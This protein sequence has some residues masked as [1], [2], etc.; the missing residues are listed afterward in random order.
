MFRAIQVRST[1]SEKINK[2]KEY[3]TIRKIRY[4]M[5][6]DIL[7]VVQLPKIA[8]RLVFRDAQIYLFSHGEVR[9]LSGKVSRYSEH[10]FSQ[11]LIDRLF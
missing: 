1:T 6:Y 11:D 4:E 7:A 2:P 9:G 3:R 5:L 8:G 10:L